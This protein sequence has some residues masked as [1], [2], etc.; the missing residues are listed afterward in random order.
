MRTPDLF[1]ATVYDN[2]ATG[3][4]EIWIN[5]KRTR[6]CRKNAICPHAVWEEMRAPWGSYPDVPQQAAA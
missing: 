2:T 3:C 6:Y 5:G 4:R 1:D